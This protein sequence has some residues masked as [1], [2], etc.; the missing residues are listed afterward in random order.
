MAPW[1][2]ILLALVIFLNGNLAVVCA[3]QPSIDLSSE[4]DQDDGPDKFFPEEQGHKKGYDEKLS[5]DLLH[6]T[7]HPQ[8]AI[9]DLSHTACTFEEQY[10]H[11][12]IYVFG[13]LLI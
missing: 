13:A 7:L 4:E 12:L 5:H 8:D 2:R 6:L 1:L 11:C 3:S 9:A 10:G